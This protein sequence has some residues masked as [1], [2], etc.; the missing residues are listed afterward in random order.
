MHLCVRYLTTRRGGRVIDPVGESHDHH[1]IWHITHHRSPPLPLQ[2]ISTFATEHL[3]IASTGWLTAV[4]VGCDGP[5]ASWPT[6]A[7]TWP[8]LPATPGGMCKTGK[9]LAP[10]INWSNG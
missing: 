10:P 7:T 8:T 1:M 9:S 3:C 4:C 6:T 2:L 5:M